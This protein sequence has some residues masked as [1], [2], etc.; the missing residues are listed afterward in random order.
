MTIYKQKTTKYYVYAWLRSDGT[1]YYIGKGCGNRSGNRAF[2][3]SRKTHPRDHG[4]VLILES[5][6][7]EIGALALER[8][9]IRWY[10]RKDLGTGILRNMTDG[11]DGVSGYKHTPETLKRI[12]HKGRKRSDNFKLQVSKS[13]A[14]KPNHPQTLETRLKISH[15]QKGRPKPKHALLTCPHCN[16]TGGA[17][18]MKRYHFD[19]CNHKGS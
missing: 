2:D 5:N 12:N 6:L 15:A 7:T 14:G 4:R 13:K 19:N 10:G 3:R 18:G 1:P 17:N 16:K 11:G 8:R 9:Y